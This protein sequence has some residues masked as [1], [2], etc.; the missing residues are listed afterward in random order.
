MMNDDTRQTEEG[1]SEQQTHGQVQPPDIG[2]NDMEMSIA[3]QI[4]EHYPALDVQEG[5]PTSDIEHSDMEL[6]LALQASITEEQ[7][8]GWEPLGGPLY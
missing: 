2:H 3:I 4:D 5:D 6:A 7:V 1:D 8:S